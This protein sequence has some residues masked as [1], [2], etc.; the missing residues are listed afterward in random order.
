MT[1]AETVV[2]EVRSLALLSPDRA[3]VRWTTPFS[4]EDR[5][6]LCSLEYTFV[7]VL[8]CDRGEVWYISTPGTVHRLENK[9]KK[10]LFDNTCLRR[11]VGRSKTAPADDGS[12]E[13][14]RRNI[15]LMPERVLSIEETLPA[16]AL[17][18]LRI[19]H[20]LLEVRADMRDTRELGSILSRLEG[21]LSPPPEERD[22]MVY[23]VLYIKSDSLAT[24]EARGD[25]DTMARLAACPE[26]NTSAG[27]QEN[28]RSLYRD[29]ALDMGEAAG[30]RYHFPYSMVHGKGRLLA[31]VASVEGGVYSVPLAALQEET[32]DAVFKI[33]VDYNEVE[34]VESM[35]ECR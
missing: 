33:K 19:G 29:L 28:F 31:D 25:G 1:R 12:G 23:P 27:L 3:L 9:L 21:F 14:V 5:R 20:S 2:S 8:L 34:R 18:V 32:I 4:R 10:V 30:G 15:V 26:Y 22:R 17:R 6:E 13:R 16:G 11:V 35:E 24:L 7:N